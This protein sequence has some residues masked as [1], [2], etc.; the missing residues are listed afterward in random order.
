M[1][2]P[3]RPSQ[4]SSHPRV[5]RNRCK[6]D[7]IRTYRK[8]ELVL[9]DLNTVVDQIGRQDDQQEVDD[10]EATCHGHRRTYIRLKERGIELRRLPACQHIRNQR[11][12][13]G[14][15]RSRIA[16]HGIASRP[17]IIRPNYGRP[18]GAQHYHVAVGKHRETPMNKLLRSQISLACVTASTPK[19]FGQ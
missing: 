10:K 6:H 13:Y 11:D 3:I 15:Q 1:A 9:P 17:D 12:H 2:S 7:Y 4:G 14:G 18:A 8:P 19:Y 5:L 16:G